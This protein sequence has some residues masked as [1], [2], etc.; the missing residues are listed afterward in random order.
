MGLLDNV[1]KSLG[2]GGKGAE[3]R[4]RGSSDGPDC[5]GPGS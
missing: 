5:G 4:K 3:E 2:F 1:R